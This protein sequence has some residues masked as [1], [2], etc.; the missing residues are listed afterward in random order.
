MH[1]LKLIVDLMYRGG[2]NYMRYSISD[3]AEWGDYQAGPRIVTAETKKVMKQLLTEIQ[4]GEF[5]K[6]WIAENEA[7]MPNY[8]ALR[9]K[10]MT[11]PIEVVGARLRG[12]MPFLDPVQLPQ[13]S[14][15]LSPLVNKVLVADH[16]APQSGGVAG[17]ALRHRPDA[18]D[19][20]KAQVGICS[21]WYEGNPCNMH[22]DRLAVDVKAG[23][24]SAGLVGMRFN[25][26]GVSDAISMGT[27]GM[28]FSLPSRDLIAD[29]IETVMGA[30]WYDGWSRFPA[31]TRTCPAA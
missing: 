15:R 24:E 22:L 10:D 6:K 7:G 16:P 19:M 11:H 9:E 28:S 25:T 5:A 31:A 27:P 18:A 20:Q 8:K 29:S 3:T 23:V 14:T 21:M 17:H 30:Q 12:M 4:S 26:I 2:L 13:P 1:E